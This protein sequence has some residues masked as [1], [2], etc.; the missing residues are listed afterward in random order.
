MIKQTLLST[1]ITF[2]AILAVIYF[3]PWDNVN[4]GTV[5]MRPSEVVTVTGYAESQEGNQQSSFTAGVS[6][7]GDDKQVTIDEVNGKIADIVEKVKAF[8]IAD[9][10]IKTQN[11]SIYQNQEPYYENGV[12]KSRLGQWNVSNNV[13]IILRDIAKVDGLATL[14]AST[15]ANNVWGPNYTTG[16]SREAQ[17]ALLGGAIENARSKA[18]EAAKAT[19]KKLG[20]V[21]SVTEAG[22]VSGPMPFY[23]MGMGGGGGFSGQPGTST[24]SQTVTVTFELR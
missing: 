15:G 11:M 20:K 24:V 6:A 23:D 21:L 14:L 3:F 7:V 8:G 10:D 13:E 1:V 5:S 16:D 9:A 22:A 2:A 17:K 12:S 18:E 4:W 19:G